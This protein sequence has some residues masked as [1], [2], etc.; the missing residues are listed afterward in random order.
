MISFKNYLV[1]DAML[2]K[3]MPDEDIIK[4]CEKNANTYL[5]SG[6]ST[7]F[8]GMNSISGNGGIIN[9]NDFTRKSRNT[10]NYYTT[11]LDN[12]PDWSKYPKRSKSYICSTSED[13]TYGYGETCYVII[14]SDNLQIGVCSEN[15][16][17][18]SFEKFLVDG[19]NIS[20]L[21]EWNTCISDLIKVEEHFLSEPFGDTQHNYGALTKFLKYM[22]VNSL[23]ELRTFKDGGLRER[24]GVN[25]FIDDLLKFMK[26]HG[27]S[28]MFEVWTLVFDPEQ[29]GFSVESSNN[30]HTQNEVEIW[31]Q[32][33]VAAVKY[34][35]KNGP[36][37]EYLNSRG[38]F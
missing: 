38:I 9:T 15:D 2:P 4:W 25:D 10:F 33:E 21:E 24:L 12:S 16:F 27:L 32:G 14:P 31:I 36:L 34:T 29:N 23:N 11:W 22:T 20:S 3:P 30:F 1:E 28:N 18:Y 6:S 17:W 26:Q 37:K 8:R 5:K 7:I 13:T 19:F 35:G